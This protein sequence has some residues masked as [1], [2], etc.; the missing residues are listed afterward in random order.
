MSPQAKSG[1]AVALV[2]SGIAASAALAACCAFPVLLAGVG[3]SAYWLQPVAAFAEPNSVILDAIAVLALIGSV[4][5]VVR[6]GRT[7]EPSDLCARPVFRWSIIL[8]AVVG[9]VLLVLSKVYG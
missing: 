1:G 2:A 5:L 8:A 7:C 3:L 9:A 6:A 4:A